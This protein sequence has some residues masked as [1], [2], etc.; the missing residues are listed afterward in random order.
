MREVRTFFARSLVHG[1]HIVSSVVRLPC[2]VCAVIL[3]GSCEACDDLRGKCSGFFEQDVGCGDDQ[4]FNASDS[5]KMAV[6][7]CQAIEGAN[8][9]LRVRVQL[10]LGN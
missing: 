6:A 5:S 1:R 9:N 4:S 2:A 8:E 7:N 3:G 10:S